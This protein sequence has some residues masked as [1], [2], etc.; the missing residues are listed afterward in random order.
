MTVFCKK[1]FWEFNIGMIYHVRE[2]ELNEEDYEVFILGSADVM[3]TELLNKNKETIDTVGIWITFEDETQI[4]NAMAIS[5][6]DDIK[7]YGQEGINPLQELFKMTI[8][9]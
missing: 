6:L 2:E 1:S 3:Y 9:T 7:K 5:I 8:N 4:D